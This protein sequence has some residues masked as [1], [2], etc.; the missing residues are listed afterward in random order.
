MFC[1]SRI[2]TEYGDLIVYFPL[3]PTEL[4]H[5]RIQLEQRKISKIFVFRHFL[6]ARLDFIHSLYLNLR[7]YSENNL[8]ICCS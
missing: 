6:H 2:R 4:T 3:F 7:N 1:I 5:L 8:E